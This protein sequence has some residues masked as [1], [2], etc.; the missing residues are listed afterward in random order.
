MTIDRML[1]GIDGISIDGRL[2]DAG[3]TTPALVVS[4]FGEVDDRVRGL[5]AGG[6]DYLA[7]PFAFGEAAGAGRGTVRD[8]VLVRNR[9]SRCQRR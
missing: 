4:A 3:A 5:R 8:A 7:K 2:R 1:P 9:A 6:A